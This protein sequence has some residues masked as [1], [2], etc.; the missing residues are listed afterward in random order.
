MCI[1]Q[2]GYTGNSRVEDSSRGGIYTYAKIEDSQVNGYMGDGVAGD[3]GFDFF[4]NQRDSSQGATMSQSLPVS[5][6]FFKCLE[7]CTCVSKVGEGIATNH[8]AL[9]L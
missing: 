7:E 9:P 8:L 1:F 6:E 2:Q 4:G 5:S 3:D